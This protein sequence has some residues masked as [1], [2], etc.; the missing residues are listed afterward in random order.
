MFHDSVFFVKGTLKIK[1]IKDAGSMKIQ[2]IKE[3]GSHAAS[4][5]K[6]NV[7][8]GMVQV[9]MPNSLKNVSVI[10]VIIYQPV[11]NKA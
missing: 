4:K 2:S 5:V 8:S 10:N 7:A 1:N 6:K 9:C 11:V 3:T